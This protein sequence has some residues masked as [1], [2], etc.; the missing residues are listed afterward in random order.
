MSPTRWDAWNLQ[1]NEHKQTFDRPELYDF[2]DVSQNNH[3]K[4]RKHWDNFLYV[5]KRLSKRPRPMNTTKTYGADGNKFGHSDLDAIERFWRRLLA[6]AASAR[7]H[8][9]DSGLGL[10]DK[11]VNCLKAARLVERLVPF[12][13]LRPAMERLKKKSPYAAY[14]AEAEGKAVV[15]Y[16]S[17]KGSEGI[18]LDLSGM[19]NIQDIHWI[20]ID[21]GIASQRFKLSAT[22]VLHLSTPHQGN[23]A[24]VIR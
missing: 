12:W 17:V 23:F 14:A 19:T 6:G 2:V 24:M 21:S 20:N 8:R 15:V 3:T 5:K 11:A 1:S 7:F 9:P 16:L 18:G 22:D 10:N 4:G 13:E